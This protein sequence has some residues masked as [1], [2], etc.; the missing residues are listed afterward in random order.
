MANMG[1]VPGAFGEFS[2]LTPVRLAEALGVAEV[3]LA[4]WRAKKKGPAWVKV[5]REVRYRREAVERWLAE[6][7]RSG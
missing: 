3:T 4:N 6:Q 1:D 5:G 2:L 7:E